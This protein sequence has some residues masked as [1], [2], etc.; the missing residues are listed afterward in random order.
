MP[1][2]LQRRFPTTIRNSDAEV[3]DILASHTQDIL[4]VWQ[5]QLRELKLD[6]TVLIPE[7]IDFQ[8]FAQELRESAQPAL[9]QHIR[10][11]GERL[12]QRCRRLDQAVAAFNRLFETCLRYL[13][14]STKK[15]ASSVSA[16]VRLHARVG[17]LL[18]SGYSGHWAATKKTLV[19]A[20]LFEAESCFR[21]A[22]SYV[23]HI[24]EHERKRLSQT[25]HDEIGNDLVLVK[26]YLERLASDAKDC[27]PV[28]PQL[29]ETIV[30]VSQVIDSVRRIGFDLGPAIF[31]ELAFLPA[32]KAYIRNFSTRTKIPVALHQKRFP[33]EIPMS[34]QTALYR[35]MQGA[36][37]NVLQHSL[38]ESV[39]ITLGSL[40]HNAINMVVA[41]DGVGFNT[42]RN[43]G[44]RSVGL[45][46][47]R[48]RV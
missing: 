36:L 6:A 9:Q 41:D 33:A 48:D 19:E 20:S 30:L 44:P 29:V 15:R 40:N 45:I 17:P 25:L 37:S 24:F 16:L 32:V 38:A 21:D 31:K 42:E 27:P 11:F 43:H 2:A 5:E 22:E 13:A 28:R 34:H 10:E 4:E 12:A 26:L 35:L 14:V 47:M 39:T 8:E 18:M 23:S 7:G 46:S 3:L 1:A